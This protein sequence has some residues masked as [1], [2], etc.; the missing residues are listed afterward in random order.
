ML[1]RYSHVRMA[2]KRAALEAIST[3][4]PE[5]ACGKVTDSGGDVHKIGNQ[6]EMSENSAVSKLWN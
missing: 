5:T 4:L 3:P 6:I 1:E 2:A